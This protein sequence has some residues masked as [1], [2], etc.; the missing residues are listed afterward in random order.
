MSS[1]LIVDKTK[2]HNQVVAAL[3]IAATSD[4]EFSQMENANTAQLSH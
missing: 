2:S 1:T 4:R 3:I